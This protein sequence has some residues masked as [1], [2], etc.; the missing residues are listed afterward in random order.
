M[1]T[2]DPTDGLGTTGA[3]SGADTKTQAKELIGQAGQTLKHEAQTFAAA[4]QDKARDEVQKHTQTATK[5]LG[6]FATA[7]RRAGDDLAQHDQ[8]LAGRL[9]GRAAD[10]LETLSR[11]LA[12]K[13]PEDLLAAVRDF[14]RKNPMAFIGGSVLVGL[15]L[16]RFVRASGQHRQAN[17]VSGGSPWPA[18]ESTAYGA[19]G[20]ITAF[21]DEALY[22]D[23]AEFDGAESSA[24]SALKA[25]LADDLGGLEATDADDTVNGPGGASRGRFDPGV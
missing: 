10:G 4:A 19:E 18:A 15:A 13:Q 22:D 5:T 8:S 3:S 2:I 12:D 9:V 21:S 20:D 23:D 17:T 25:P 7:V 6:D 1:S 14:G 11:N 24:T 16:G